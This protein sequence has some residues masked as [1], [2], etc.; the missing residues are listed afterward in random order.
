MHELDRNK[1]VLSM[2]I[3]MHSI[4][5][6]RYKRRSLILDLVIFSSSAILAAF[7]F[8]DYKY[9]SKINISIE[10]A[11]F[12]VGVFSLLIFVLTIINLIVRW[13]ENAE[14]HH[15][16]AIQLF[17]LLNEARYLL[18][19]EDNEER[20]SLF[21][22]FNLKYS[23]IQESLVKIPDKKFNSLKSKHL[24]K[25][26]LSKML[27]S[28]PTMPLILLKIKLLINAKEIHKSNE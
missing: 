23:E 2:M 18:E 17:K 16:A 10:D 1:K 5:R 21:R 14:N 20:F 28:N 24:K 8:I 4:L 22:A 6:D 19:M 27:D 13:K 26:I 3:T 25:M 7:V 11:Q 12:I 9:F 15:K